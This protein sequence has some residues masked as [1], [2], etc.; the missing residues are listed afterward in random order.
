[1][2]DAIRNHRVLFAGLLAVLCSLGV[3]LAGI[4]REAYSTVK[5]APLQIRGGALD[6]ADSLTWTSPISTAASTL[7][8]FPTRGNPTLAVSPRFSVDSS[9]AII[10]VG[11]FHKSPADVYTFMGIAG[12]Q[13]ATGFGGG[14]AVDTN[15][16]YMAPTLFFDTAGANYYEVRKTDPSA[17]ST[18]RLFV[19][20]YGADAKGA[21]VE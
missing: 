19:W 12:V 15:G 3:A 6:G 7:S 16:E 1:M 2:R 13:T 5:K 20:S 14:L 4:D 9:Q 8:V 11:L 18:I 21:K 10:T 17:T